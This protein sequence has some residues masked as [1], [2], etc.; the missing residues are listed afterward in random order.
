MVDGKSLS[1]AAMSVPKNSHS[2][3]DRVPERSIVLHWMQDVQKATAKI[4][5]N[6]PIRVSGKWS[7]DELYFPTDKGGRYMAGVMYAESR[8]MLANETY[9]EENK[10]QVYDATSVNGTG[11]NGP[12]P[13]NAVMLCNYA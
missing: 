4:S 9:P 3:A 7:T 13:S 10:L 11:Q 8:F 6:V 5:E 1:A 2:G 12:G